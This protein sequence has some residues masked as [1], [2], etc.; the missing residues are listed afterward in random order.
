MIIGRD[1][2]GRGPKER[3]LWLSAVFDATVG[4]AAVICRVVTQGVILTTKS[5]D[6]ASA[7]TTDPF[8]FP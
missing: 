7:L 5:T 8:D 1:S 2:D 3:V 4:K 6:T